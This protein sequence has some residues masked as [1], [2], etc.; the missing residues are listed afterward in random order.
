MNFVANF[1][2]VNTI[3]ISKLKHLLD[4]YVILLPVFSISK[5]GDGG[6]GGGCQRFCDVT[7]GGGILLTL[8]TVTRGEGGQNFRKKQRYVTFE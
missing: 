8:R 2:R 1:V 7:E 3:F 5:G 6:G 4:I